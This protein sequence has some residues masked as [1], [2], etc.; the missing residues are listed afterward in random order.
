MRGELGHRL[1]A[2]AERHQVQS[3]DAGDGEQLLGE[4]T[5]DGEAVALLGA[6]GD[7]V[8]H[9]RAEARQAL[10]Q[11]SRARDHEAGQDRGALAQAGVAD[12]LEPLGERLGVE[13]HLRLDEGRAGVDLARSVLERGLARRRGGADQE[14][15]RHVELEPVR[16]AAVREVGE[17][18]DEAGRVDVAHL[19]RVDTLGHRIA[20]ERKDRLDAE[21][22]GADRVGGERKAIAVARRH[23]QDRPA[24]GLDDERGGG[25]R[26]HAR[27]R[28]RQVGDVERVC[29][30][31]RRDLRAHRR[32]VGA[33]RAARARR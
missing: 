23:L 26:R 4:L 31:E 24:A 27:A 6:L 30:R 20:E 13:H 32:R 15:R 2:R 11:R 21:R 17:Q 12:G 3:G 1:G 7:A 5:G 8:G 29:E 25:E 28:L 14:R 16:R 22:R 19:L 33:A 18:R 9:Q 10:D